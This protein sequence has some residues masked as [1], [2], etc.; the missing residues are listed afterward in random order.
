VSTIANAMGLASRSKKWLV[1]DESS[2]ST[3]SDLDAG[4]VALLQ[5]MRAMTDQNRPEGAGTAFFEWSKKAAALEGQQP[6]IALGHEFVK[7]LLDIVLQPAKGANIPYSSKVLQ[8]LLERRAVSANM[9]EGGL[10]HALK[11]RND[12]RSISL[13]FD[14]VLDLPETEIVDL[15]Q[16][17]VAQHRQSA[18]NSTDDAMQ[19][20]PVPSDLPSLP[21]FLSSCVSYATSPAP[22]R[23]AIRQHLSDAEDL[24]CVLEI[25]SGWVARSHSLTIKLLPK[26]VVKNAGGVMVAKPRATKKPDGPPIENVLSFLQTLLDASFLALLQHPPAHDILRRISS[27]LEPELIRI[28]DMEQLRGPLEPFARAQMKA[29]RESAEGKRDN[30]VDWRKRRKAAHEQTSAAVG[31]YRLEDLVL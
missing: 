28:D 4:Q 11:L 24:A 6:D 18:T 13:S 21:S 7:E 14:A 22:L 30:Q 26:E 3:F 2:P 1:Q 19:I 9:I 23:L 29:L 17:V 16:S 12:W 31:L 15:L 8:F 20:D 27:D 5:S 10:L 25:L